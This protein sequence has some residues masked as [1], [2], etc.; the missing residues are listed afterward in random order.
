YSFAEPALSED[1]G[2]AEPQ[3]VWSEN[4]AMLAMVIDKPKSINQSQVFDRSELYMLD[5]KPIGRSTT[6]RPVT[7]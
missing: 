7:R 5:L 1:A 3:F 6:A 2:C 4:G